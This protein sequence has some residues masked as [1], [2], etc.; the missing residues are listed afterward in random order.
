MVDII[1]ASGEKEEFSQEKI[2]QSL[3][4]AGV[5]NALAQKI[6]NEIS[7][8]AH[9]GMGS[10]EIFK[11]VFSSLKKEEP[12][13]ALRYNLKKAIMDL[14]PTGFPFEKYIAKI[15]EEYGYNTEVGRLVRGHCVTHE[16]DVVA[17]KGDQHFMVECKYHNSQGIH[18]D[19]KVA[20]YT[21]ARFLD[22]KQVWE[23]MPGHKYFFHQA[24]LVT[25]TKCTSQA[26]RYANCVGLKIVSWR[27]P[28][29]ESLERLIEK[30]NL[31]PVTILSLPRFFKEQLI[32]N[33][34]VLVKDL[35]RYTPQNLSNMIKLRL[36]V[37]SRIQREARDLCHY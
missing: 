27:Y 19:V 34:I 22:I 33:N 11:E 18:S 37:A 35:L 30:K 14:G 16:V 3:K 23:E 36:G 20:L 29:E 7:K 9:P 2:N 25:N 26:V 10:S 17:R 21:Q 28:K 12:I 6:T 24:W 5:E 15:L 4:R 8:K 13:A 31:Y 32:Q 1:K